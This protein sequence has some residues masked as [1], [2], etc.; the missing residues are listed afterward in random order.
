VEPRYWSWGRD[1][2]PMLVD[3]SNAVRAGG[4]STRTSLPSVRPGRRQAQTWIGAAV[5]TGPWTGADPEAAK[6]HAVVM[7]DLGLDAVT[8]AGLR[9]QLIGP[10]QCLPRSGTT[11]LRLPVG[12][13]TTLVELL[14][15]RRGSFVSL[16]T[17][18]DVLWEGAPPPT[19]A[20]NV[21]SL[22]SRV[23]RVLGPASISGGGAGY[24]FEL[25][26]AEVDVDV[27]ERLIA[28]AEAQLRARHPA[29]A[30]SAAA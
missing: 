24:R 12:K 22:V 27:A 19:A 21:A 29:L 16:D 28:E 15:L 26:A 6:W 4:R 10:F 11:P 7:A 9:V 14:V 8:N 2:L 17:V 25:G 3:I 30:A 23:R 18:E 20:Q 5:R 13:A 1:D